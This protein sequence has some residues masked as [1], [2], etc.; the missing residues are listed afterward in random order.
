[1][2]DR[3]HR[4]LAWLDRSVMWTGVPAMAAGTQRKRHLRWPPVVALVLASGG[5]IW[6]VTNPAHDVFIGSVLIIVGFSIANLMPIW[7][8]LRRFSERADEF[9]RQQRRDSLLVGLTTVALA[10]F[11]G[12]W[13]T[14]SLMAMQI[15]SAAVAQQELISFAFYMMALFGAVPTLHASWHTR[16]LADEDERC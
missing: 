2:S 16:P 4:F 1:M 9:E 3:Q 6:C 12:I 7:G 8:P 14:V 10:G 15:W 11:V 13:L 5:L